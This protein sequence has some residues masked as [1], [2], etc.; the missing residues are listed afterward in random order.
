MIEIND[1]KEIL[2]P[3]AQDEKYNDISMF[4]K[5]MK[6]PTAVILQRTEEMEKELVLTEESSKKTVLE[7][8]I[9]EKR[10]ANMTVEALKTRIRRKKAVIE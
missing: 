2:E 8:K 4:S 9:L 5:L 6:L 1:E 7:R 10:I 3:C